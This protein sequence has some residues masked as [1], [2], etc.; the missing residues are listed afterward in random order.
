MQWDPEELRKEDNLP[1][2]LDG[3]APA[4]LSAWLRVGLQNSSE[5]QAPSQAQI[6]T[7]L[8]WR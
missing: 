3:L 4:P 2:A 1:P 6:L 5:V 7:Y 8:V